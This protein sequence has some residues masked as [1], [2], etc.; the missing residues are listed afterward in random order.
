[1]SY[2]DAM[3]DMGSFYREGRLVEQDYAKAME[4][5]NKA[6]A[7]GNVKAMYEIYQMHL[8]GEGVQPNFNL[9]KE[10]LRK[11]MD[12]DNSVLNGFSSVKNQIKAI[13]KEKN[14]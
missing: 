13:I 3:A 8:R 6:A 10:W 4:Y 1:M 2:P 7:K 9:A 11:S 14:K 12:A 5:L